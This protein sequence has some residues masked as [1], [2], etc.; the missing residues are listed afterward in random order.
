MIDL[1]RVVCCWSDI[2][3][4]LPFT[5]THPKPPEEVRADNN[6]LRYTPSVHKPG[7]DNN[8][9]PVDAS[10]INIETKWVAIEGLF[11]LHACR[12]R[13]ACKAYGIHDMHAMHVGNAIHKMYAMHGGHAMH[14]IHGIYAMHGGH[15]K[16]GIHE[17]HAMHE[18]HAIHEMYAM[19]GG[20]GIHEMHV[21]FADGSMH[22]F[23]ES[24]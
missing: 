16:H 20:H 5:L 7:R 6:S 24:K 2:L 15:A 8:D 3:L 9:T 21:E 18:G 11:I 1:I 17:M 4:E 13:R 23:W 14:G 22:A 19:H 10:F 12:E